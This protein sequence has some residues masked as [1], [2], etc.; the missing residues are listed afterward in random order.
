MK[1]LATLIFD[2][3]QQHTKKLVDKKTQVLTT[4]DEDEIANITW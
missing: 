2:K 1:D 4:L 3:Q